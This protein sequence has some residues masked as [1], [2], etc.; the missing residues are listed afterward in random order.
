[1]KPFLLCMVAL[2]LF[3][4]CKKEQLSETTLT[5]KWKLIK[6]HNLS[7][8]TVETEPADA[9]RSVIMDFIDNGITGTMD[10][11]TE[12][13]EVGGEYELLQNNQMKTI[14]FGGTKI[15]EPLWSAKFWNA[16]HTASSYK[17]Q[18]NK[19]LIHFNKHNEMMEFKGE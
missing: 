4:G 19:L 10:G 2:C 7:N 17:R 16:M 14:C 13:N 11:H 1:M 5:G 3:A 8:Q 18:G 9:Q 12:M 6:Y 15:G